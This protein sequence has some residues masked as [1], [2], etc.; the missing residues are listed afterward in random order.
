ME[1]VRVGRQ[2]LELADAVEVAQQGTVEAGLVGGLQF[3]RLQDA[4]PVE[5]LVGAGHVVENERPIEVDL[6]AP[7]LGKLD[8]FLRLARVAFPSAARV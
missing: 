2:V 3:G 8:P 7:A 6:V 5:A 1:L 4:T